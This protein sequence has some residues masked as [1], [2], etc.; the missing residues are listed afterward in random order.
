[1]SQ[2]WSASDISNVLSSAFVPQASSPLSKVASSSSSSATKKANGV[3]SRKND[4]GKGEAPQATIDVLVTFDGYGV[5]GH[6]NHISLYHGAKA[7]LGGMMAGKAGWGCPVDLYTLASTTVV[8]KY[9]AILD[10]PI[11]L[12]LGVVRNVFGSANGKKSE[13]KKNEGPRRLFFVNDIGRWRRG[14][15]AMSQ[16]HKSQMR[17]FRWGWISVGRYMVVNDLRRERIT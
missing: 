17:W 12:L 13:K 1:M 4:G 3:T 10:A 15:Q 16:G 6:A 11:T 8:R 5:S 7:W 14:Q 2:S 9:S